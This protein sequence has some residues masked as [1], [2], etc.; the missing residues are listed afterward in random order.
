[1]NPIK[2]SDW[3]KLVFTGCDRSLSTSDELNL[4]QD[5]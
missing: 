5:R 2:T 4:A 1:M 3:L